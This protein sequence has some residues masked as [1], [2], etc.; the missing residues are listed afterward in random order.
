MFA[1]PRRLAVAAIAP[2]QR[3]KFM[4]VFLDFEASS[5]ADRS[6][7]IEVAWVFENGR[8]ETY[9]IRPAPNW[10]DW[11]PVAESIHGI[12][13]ARLA[14]EGERHDVI[15][16]R[17]V[18]ALEGHD[19]LAS[20]PSWDGK[21]L[22]ALLRAAGLPRHALRLRGTDAAIAEAAAAV[23][24][25]SVPASSLRESV[26]ALIREVRHGEAIPVHRALPDARAE[27]GRWEAVMDRARSMAGVH[28]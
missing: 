10:T 24:G 27:R 3:S 6:H 1:E 25:R 26:T 13:R 21:W 22:S 7:P 9:L 23:L 14:R 8:S 5:L 19:L 12:S 18:D 28:G 20:A 16:R 2:A 15:A 4:R 11:S 17:M